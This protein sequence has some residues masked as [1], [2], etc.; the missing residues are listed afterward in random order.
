VNQVTKH[1]W[2]N[3]VF[4]IIQNTTLLFRKKLLYFLINI[5]FSKVTYYYYLS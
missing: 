5:E 4:F 1:K 2:L 3:G